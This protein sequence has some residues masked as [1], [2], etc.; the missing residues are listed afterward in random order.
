MKKFSI[1]T[2]TIF[3][4]LILFCV[5]EL[6]DKG[7]VLI[8]RV[9]NLDNI[10]RSD[11]DDSFLGMIFYQDINKSE[12]KNY[13]RLPLS[14][15]ISNNE[16]NVEGKVLGKFYYEVEEGVVGQGH[17]LGTNYTTTEYLNQ[18]VESA[19]KDIQ[20]GSLKQEYQAQSNLTRSLSSISIGDSWE[21]IWSDK[22]VWSLD[23]EGIHFGD[24]SEWY[25]TYQIITSDYSYYLITHES[26]IS[27]NNDNTDDFRSSQLIYNFNPNNE[28]ILLRDYYPKAKN[29]NM[30]VSYGCDVGAEIDSDGTASVNAGVSSSYSTILESPKIYDRGNMAQNEVDIL[31]E[32]VDPWAEDDTYYP[33]NTGQSM[34]TSIYLLREDAGR[35]DL[36]DMSDIRTV[37]MVRDHSLFW[38]DET[39]NF[40]YNYIYTLRL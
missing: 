29:P 22:I 23:H 6:S 7:N 31:F 1:L 14:N 15:S 3:L 27:P 28:H 8:K 24:F 19:K 5:P 12:N 18:M 11:F 37:Q 13:D 4:L 30:T 25:S 39:V 33:Y 21:L 17:L 10:S 9:D 35:T 32:Y 40:V 34:Q 16:I 36:V 38:N 20:S 26:Y 2:I